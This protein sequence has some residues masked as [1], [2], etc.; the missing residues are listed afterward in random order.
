MPQ[1]CHLRQD[2]RHCRASCLLE[3]LGCQLVVP[4][5]PWSTTG[6]VGG[7]GGGHGGRLRLPGGVHSHAPTLLH[8]HLQDRTAAAR[9][10]VMPRLATSDASHQM[11]V[12]LDCGEDIRCIREL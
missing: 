11:C 7:G 10:A 3:P 1:G 5:S 4:I 6:A 8:Q 2:G 9:S 12:L